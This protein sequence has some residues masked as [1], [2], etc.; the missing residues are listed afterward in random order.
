[1]V[2]G[3]HLKDVDVRVFWYAHSRRIGAGT[4]RNPACGLI[5]G[6]LVPQIATPTPALLPS[7]SE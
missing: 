6:S 7:P 1:M 5:P 3:L 2:D 4:I